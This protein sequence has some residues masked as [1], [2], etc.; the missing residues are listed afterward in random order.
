MLFSVCLSL[1]LHSFIEEQTWM[2][3]MS[4]KAGLVAL[5]AHSRKA[6]RAVANSLRNFLR[7]LG[8]S[9]GLTSTSTPSFSLPFPH[10]SSNHGYSLRNNPKQHPQNPSAKHPS[11]QHNQHNNVLRLCTIIHQPIPESIRDGY[12]CV[13]GWYAYYIC[14]VRAYYW[15]VFCMCGFDS[16]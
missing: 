5:L 6:D 4:R 8:G 7:I 11:S 12:G 16:G 1:S 13:H 2:I 9:V 3:L 10:I 14:H 15:C